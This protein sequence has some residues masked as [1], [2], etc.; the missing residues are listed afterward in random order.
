MEVD[1]NTFQNDMVSFQNKD[2][3]ITLLIHMGYLAYDLSLIHIF[4]YDIL[5]HEKQDVSFTEKYRQRAVG[6]TVCRADIYLPVYDTVYC[7]I[8]NYHD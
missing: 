5:V 6:G 2:D 8:E 4:T 3:V 7:S 1:I